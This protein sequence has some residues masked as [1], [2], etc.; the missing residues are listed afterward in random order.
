MI[1][2]PT[3]SFK[4][5]TADLP[6]KT[7]ILLK[8]SLD[9][10]LENYRHPSLQAKKLPGTD[11]WYARVDRSYR[12]TYQINKETIILRRVGTH[13]ILTHERHL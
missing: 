10:L 8:K 5:E 6:K 4:S 1:L 7:Q 11:F 12:F 2:F 13:D 9:L 3:S